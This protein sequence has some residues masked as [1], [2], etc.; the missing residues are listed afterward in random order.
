M[1]KSG[2]SLCRSMVLACYQECFFFPVIQI[3]GLYPH[4]GTYMCVYCDLNS[5]LFF[6][7]LFLEK[8]C[9]LQ[10]ERI[11]L[12][13]NEV[14]KRL[15]KAQELTRLFNS[16]ELL[17]GVTPTDYGSLAKV[18]EQFEPFF[19]LWSSA[20]DWKRDN[21]SWMN[22]PFEQLVPDVVERNVTGWWKGLFKYQREFN[23]REL[24]SQANS[25]ETIRQQVH[26]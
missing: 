26:F 19:Y 3:L 11:A 4:K 10:V 25:C 9:F 18:I 8:N 24:A 17:F 23:K 1:K 13:A 16:R 2:L 15:R 5:C 14:D 21:A 12:D 7:F 20:A 6:S 22:D